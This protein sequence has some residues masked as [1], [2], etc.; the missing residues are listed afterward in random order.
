MD[1]IFTEFRTFLNLDLAEYNEMLQT[2]SREKGNK[3]E[4]KD[5]VQ[6]VKQKLIQQNGLLCDQTASEYTLLTW[7]LSWN[8]R[9]N[10]LLTAM[11]QA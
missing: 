4:M 11:K 6:F 3:K 5:A 10:T 7:M 8:T 2:Y 9:K 1:S